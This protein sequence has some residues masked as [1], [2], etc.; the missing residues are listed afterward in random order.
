MSGHCLRLPLS[1][2]TLCTLP[3]GRYRYVDSS[4]VYHP[5]PVRPRHLPELSTGRGHA[6]QCLPHLSSAILLTFYQ[7]ES[8]SRF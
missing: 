2:L 5:Y 8:I 1:T 4:S 3:L 7:H 6:H